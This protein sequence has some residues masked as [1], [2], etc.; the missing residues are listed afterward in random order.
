MAVTNVDKIKHSG[1]NTEDGS[2]RTET[3]RVVFDAIP[4]DIGDA[5][6]ADAG[7]TSVPAIGALFTGSTTVRC[8]SV[9]PVQGTESRLIYEVPVQYDNINPGG[10]GIVSTNPLSR[11][12]NIVWGFNIVE[13]VAEKDIKDAE[14]VNSAGDPFDP[15]LLELEYRLTVNIERNVTHYS[16]SIAFSLI[17][18]T[19]NSSVNV[20]GVTVGKGQALLTDYSA[21]A[22]YDGGI[23]YIR[24]RIAVELAK[25]HSREVANLGFYFKD[26]NDSSK[27]KHV[28]DDNGDKDT[29][30]HFL[31]V[32]STA[33]SP[34]GDDLGQTASYLTFDT[35]ES[36]SWG[37]LFL[38]TR[39]PDT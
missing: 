35:K 21:E 29:K 25:T 30:P 31:R 9:G 24:E 17:N 13:R 37:L 3:Y 8:K 4:T 34:K 10:S 20:A 27:R 33:S 11:P 38:P 23:E 5:L 26:G 18:T 28:T 1:T 6:T 14:I 19:N 7:G 36:K 2:R 39:F 22:Q 15:P 32:T 16:P 12:A